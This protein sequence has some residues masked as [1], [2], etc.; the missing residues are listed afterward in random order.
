MGTE[1]T[2]CK[3]CGSQHTIRYGSFRGIQRYWCKDCQRKFADNKALP[4]MKTPSKQIEDTMSMYYGGMPL[5]SIQR[6]LYQE[7]NN[8]L[9]ESGIYNWIIRFSKE[10]TNRARSFKPTV[11][12]TWVADETV[13][14]V[15]RKNIWFW[16]I[17]DVKSRYLLASHLSTG[18]TTT[19]AKALVQQASEVAG[20]VPK[21]IVTDYLQAY[22]DAIEQAFGADTTH[23]KDRPFALKNLN[24]II[25]RYHGTMKDRINVMR[26]FRN[27][28][29]ARILT[30]GWLVHY[31]FFKEHEA[32]GNVPP[33]QKM[34]VE[35]PFK[36]WAEVVRETVVPY[37]PTKIAPTIVVIRTKPQT[38]DITQRQTHRKRSS[39]RVS[40]SGISSI[41]R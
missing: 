10:A 28:R 20:K 26:G 41:R 16:D 27:M 35:V 3:Y 32:L 1:N 6:H 11:G 12:D 40:L 5:D 8:Y 15:G 34:G 9:S 21:V 37:R 31:N 36:N 13:I 19:D 17:I 33:A 7:Y 25:E 18:R 24:N 39:H 22:I 4:N 14:K 2:R 38:P 23:I 30:N 29:T